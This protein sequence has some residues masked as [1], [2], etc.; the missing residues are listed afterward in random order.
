MKFLSYGVMTYMLLA[1][2]WWTILLNRNN[3]VIYQ[4][5]IELYHTVMK[6]DGTPTMTDLEFEKER[7]LYVRNRWMII[8]EG[9]VFGI[10]LTIGMYLIQK[11]FNKE[12]AQTRSQKNFLL[13]VTHELKSPIAAINLITQTLIKRNVEGQKKMEL[14]N[15]ILSE[16]SRLENLINNLLMATKLDNN[17]QYNFEENDLKVLIDKCVHSQRI[18]HP[19]VELLSNIPDDIIVV[20]DRESLASVFLNLIENGIKYNKNE[21]SIDINAKIKGEILEVSVKD[22]GIG[23][24]EEEKNKVFQQFYRI[25]NE[26][27]RQTKGTGLGLYIVSKIIKAHNGR[28]KIENNLG[29][30]TIFTVSLPAW[31]IQS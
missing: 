18:S 11:T 13:S 26:E 3:N 19:D 25:G 30:G 8:G 22:D 27:T 14:H 10:S 20:G 31:K 21:K 15:S 29:G 5:N 23:I 4:K 2:I 28:I 6:S 9:L 12:V 1:L 16:S 24:P 7:S 17:Y